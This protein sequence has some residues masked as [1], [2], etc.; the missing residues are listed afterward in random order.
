MQAR[1]VRVGGER[2]ELFPRCDDYDT[3]GSHLD[4]R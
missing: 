2:E 3:T 1:S 4:E